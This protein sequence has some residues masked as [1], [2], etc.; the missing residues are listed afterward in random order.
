[1]KRV[2][3]LFL[4]LFLAIGICFLFWKLDKSDSGA[5]EVD[6]NSVTYNGWPKV[7]GAGDRHEDSFR[8]CSQF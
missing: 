6:K 2:V 8:E 1:M 5:P 3:S 7:N 4:I